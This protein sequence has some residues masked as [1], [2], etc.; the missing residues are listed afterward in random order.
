MAGVAL[1][2]RK[3]TKTSFIGD[4]VTA[5]KYAAYYFRGGIEVSIWRSALS[6][7]R[8]QTLSPAWRLAHPELHRFGNRRD[9]SYDG[10]T[11]S[12]ILHTMVGSLRRVNWARNTGLMATIGRSREA[13]TH[14]PKN[15]RRGHLLFH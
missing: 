6:E 2:S 8:A 4:L 1:T 11:T 10:W 13:D 12:T 3:I 5:K 9:R 14:C 7:R 15:T